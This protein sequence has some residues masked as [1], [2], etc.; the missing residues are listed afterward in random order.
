VVSFVFDDFR[1]SAY[2]TGGRILKSHGA[3][4]TYYVSLGLMAEEGNTRDGFTAQD[5]RDL[6]QDGHEL[7]C[8]TFGHF[9]APFTDWNKFHEDVVKNQKQLDGILPGYRFRHFAYPGGRVNLSVKRKMGRLF[10]SCRGTYD[11]TNGRQADLNLLRATKLYSH[12]PFSEVQARLRENT[13]ARGWL[14]LY[15]HD[16]RRD[17]SEYGCTPEDFETA[18]K[19]AL[20]CKSQILNIGQ[21]LAL[22]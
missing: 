4:G 22:R 10:D 7:A 1:S 15:T 18:V 8:H 16:V 13:E 17:C 21:T 6:V 2:S 5:L 20:E 12:R 3:L 19:F 11:G 9:H 14:I